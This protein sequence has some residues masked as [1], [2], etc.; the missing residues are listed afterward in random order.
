M[1]NPKLAIVG[2]GFM[3]HYHYEGFTLAGSEIVAIA[4]SNLDRAKAFCEGREI[5]HTY[6]SMQEMLAA[7][8]DIDGLSIITPNKFHN[9]L[10]VEALKKGKHVFCEKPPALNARELKEM[11]DAAESSG[12]IL[13]FNF[14]N[15]ARPESQAIYNYI[16]N[17]RVGKINSAQ[18]T[19]IRRAGIPA[20]G[21]W[22][23]SKAFSGGGAMIDLPHMLDLALWFMGYPEPDYL[24]GVTYNDFMGNQAFKGPWGMPDLS[25]ITDVESSCHAMVTFKSGQS[26]MIRSSWAELV[27]RELVSVTFQGSKMGGK[28]ERLFGI[29]GV[30]ATSF[31]SVKLFTEEYG[32]QVNLDIKAEKDES[33]GRIGN[34]KNF[35]ESIAGAAKP[36]N[37][38]RE[39]LII[40]KI[41][42]ALY[43]SAASGKPVQIN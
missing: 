37:T 7:H 41:L 38:P 31:D 9:P 21:S 42:D 30:D 12:K 1:K 24:L 43:E 4:D 26:L 34:A 28:V 14:N 11:K 6:S 2:A 20:F 27:E 8:P 5:K 13:M 17:N 10:T 18:A 15:R 3:A 23:T 32:N 22:F 29:D 33:M 36:N 25:G 16:K 35:A 39:A 40:M 19:W